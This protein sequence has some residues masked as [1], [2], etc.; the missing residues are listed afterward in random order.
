MVVVLYS[1]LNS[2]APPDDKDPS[3]IIGTDP[4]V[5]PWRGDTAFIRTTI[6]FEALVDTMAFPIQQFAGSGLRISLV[7]FPPPTATTDTLSFRSMV[8]YSANY[9]DIPAVS[10]PLRGEIP[11]R[12][13]RQHNCARMAVA[14]VLLH[15]DDDGDEHYTP[16]EEILGACEQSLY[17]F[18]Q[19]DM[20]TV[21]KPPFETI[22]EGNNILIRNDGNILPAFRS[23]PD[24]HAT[25]F[26]L[27]VRGEAHRYNIPQPWPGPALP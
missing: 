27:S 8:S 19:G 13:F 5:D 1:G 20:R 6:R 18:T 25:I 10:L 15:R 3:N 4:C 11:P 14:T 16:G 12:Y 24:Y 17:A 26:I 23:S 7:L 2:C 9:L 22:F 21:P